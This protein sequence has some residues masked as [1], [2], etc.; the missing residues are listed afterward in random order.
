M[1]MI[2]NPN[3]FSVLSA[4]FLLG[5]ICLVVKAALLDPASRDEAVRRRMTAER[6]IDLSLGLPLLIAGGIFNVLGSVS[7]LSFN[8]VATSLMLGLAYAFLIYLMTYDLMVDRV[9]GDQTVVSPRAP[10]LA[11]VSS[12][13]PS[14][15]QPEAQ[16][17]RPLITA[18]EAAAQ[19]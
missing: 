14:L 15:P 2:A 18:K 13:T 4:A 3:W 10:K 1:T 17:A 8:G 12:V 7:Q 5:G 16:E 19:I 6:K 11:V 9:L